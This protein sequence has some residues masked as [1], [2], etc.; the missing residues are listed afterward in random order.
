MANRTRRLAPR[1]RKVDRIDFWIRRRE[2]SFL[3]EG[4]IWCLGLSDLMRKKVAISG[5]KVTSN[6]K[7]FK[8]PLLNFGPLFLQF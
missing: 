8:N 4:A 3:P 1:W 6:L 2:S 5:Q 7:L